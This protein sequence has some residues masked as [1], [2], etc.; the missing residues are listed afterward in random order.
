MRLYNLHLI[1]TADQAKALR[2]LT[3]SKGRSAVMCTVSDYQAEAKAALLAGGWTEALEFD[4]TNSHHQVSIM[5]ATAL[6]R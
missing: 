5:V 4:N 2:R 6:S 1:R 3:K